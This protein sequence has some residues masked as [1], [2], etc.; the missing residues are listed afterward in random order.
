MPQA[1][2]SLLVG[3]R[4]VHCTRNGRSCDSRLGVREPADVRVF[5]PRPGDSLRR[6]SIPIS[7]IH[8]ISSRCQVSGWRE[9]LSCFD[10]N[11]V[12]CFTDYPGHHVLEGGRRRSSRPVTPSNYR[13]KVTQSRLGASRDLVLTAFDDIWNDFS[14]LQ[15]PRLHRLRERLGTDAESRKHALFP[16]CWDSEKCDGAPN[17]QV[18]LK[19][20]Q[21]FLVQRLHDFDGSASRTCWSSKLDGSDAERRRV[22]R[23]IVAK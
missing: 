16:P 11:I 15:L 17:V 13:F 22:H 6:V 19:T 10:F 1:V 3:R 23:R 2:D 9:L 5:R 21:D 7:S 18:V 20:G 14:H 4:L 12:P 8:G